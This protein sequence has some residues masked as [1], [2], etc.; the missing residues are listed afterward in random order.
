VESALLVND[1]HELMQG[2]TRQLHLLC[3]E[4][5]KYFDN[6]TVRRRGATSDLSISNVLNERVWK[7][8]SKKVGE[9]G[10]GVSEVGAV[11]GDHDTTEGPDVVNQTND[12]ATES[13]K[14]NMLSSPNEKRTESVRE[15]TVD[16]NT[17]SSSS[18]ALSSL[19]AAAI[20][21]DGEASECDMNGDAAVASRSDGKSNAKGRQTSSGRG[22][23]DG[24]SAKSTDPTTTSQ[25]SGHSRPSSQAYTRASRIVDQ[26]KSNLSKFHTNFLLWNFFSSEDEID[27]MFDALGDFVGAEL[28]HVISSAS[29]RRNLSR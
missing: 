11:A 6:I 27:V 19:I 14:G 29:L 24:A 10:D 4:D 26:L 17:P 21:T 1:A 25:S 16:M 20:K 2:R 28:S 7:S 23:R 12:A 9:G 5:T 18:G 13:S 22:D 15:K 3:T 8:S